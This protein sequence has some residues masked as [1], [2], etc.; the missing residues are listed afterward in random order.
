MRNLK[1]T[2]IKCT[3]CNLNYL[4]NGS[5]AIKY[6]V[7]SK[8][9][10]K[11]KQRWYAA[12]KKGNYAPLNDFIKSNY[13]RFKIGKPKRYFQEKTKLKHALATPKW[14]NIESICEF[15]ANCP[16]G[17]HVDHIIPLNG[18]NVSGLHVAWNLQY[19]PAKEN[20]KKSNKY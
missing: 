9:Y 2:D 16:K 13:K 18:E 3:K 14:I 5:R 11:A 12:I 15:Y 7:C 20:I 6:N 10:R 8:C 19:L 17:Y 4:Y 1:K